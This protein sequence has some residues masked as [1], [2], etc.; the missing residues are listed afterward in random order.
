MANDLRGIEI[1]PP[2]QVDKTALRR[3]FLTARQNTF[4]WAKVSR[5]KLTD[6]DAE[7]KDEKVMAAFYGLRLVGFVSIYMD[8]NFIHHLYVDEEFQNRGIGT[9][10]LNVAASLTGFPLRLK[11]LEKNTKALA[12]YQSKGFN[13]T[14]NGVS[15]LGVYID[16]EKTSS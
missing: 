13:E 4:K 2:E 6:Y 12:Y 10:L 5:F 7:T 8:D 1:R 14:G 15:D 3:L 16:L 11:C 9:A